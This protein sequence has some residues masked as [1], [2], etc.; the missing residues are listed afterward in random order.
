MLT[1]DCRRPTYAPVEGTPRPTFTMG[2]GGY[3]VTN[4][5]KEKSAMGAAVYKWEADNAR[6]RGVSF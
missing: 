2:R 1:G 3:D 4:P 6:A 5:S